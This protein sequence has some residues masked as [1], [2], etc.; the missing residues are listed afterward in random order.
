[1]SAVR[2]LVTLVL[3][4]LVLVA[5]GLALL[6]TPAGSAWLVGAVADLAGERLVLTGVRGT[7]LE[8]LAVDRLQL[9]AGRT[10]LVIAP[11]ELGMSWPD[12][13]RRRLRLTTARA[14]TVR[15]DI[16]PRPPGEPDSV[17]AP[18]LLPVVI[19][20]DSLEVHRL[21]IR[22][23]VGADGGTTAEIEPVEF[24]PLVLRGELADGDLRFESL[25]AELYGV[26]VD[27]SG[28]FGTGEPF[29]LSARLDW[30]APAAGVA[31]TGRVSGDLAALRFEQ[32]LR[33]PSLVSVGGFAHLLADQPEVIAEARWQGLE[34]PLGADPGLLLRSEEGRLRVRGWTDGYAGDADA[35]FLLGELPQ[36]RLRAKA[37]GDTSRVSLPEV[38]LDGF[39]G[40][41]AGSGDIDFREALAGSFRLQARRID[42]GTLDPRFAGQVDFSA[43]VS[44]DGVGNF[45]VNLPDAG[46]T[47]F[48]LPLRAS[49]TVS[50][51]GELLAFDGVRIDA[52]PNRAELGGTWGPKIAGQFRVD[53]PDLATLWPDYA[54]QLRGTGRF[55]GTT[56]R[57][58]LDVDLAGSNLATG[59]LRIRAL[60]ARG[61]LG[62]RQQLDVDAQADG[63]VYAGR[64]V[65]DLDARVSGPLESH[66]V[67]LNLTGGDV[68]ADLRSTGSYRN[69]V[70][71]QT[72]ERGV[73]TA[74]GD[75]EWS[76]R[77]PATIR[78]AG[79]DLSVTAHCWTSAGAELCLA[80]GSYGPAQFSGGVDLLQFPLAVLNRWLPSDIGLAGTATGSL[81]VAGDPRQP[82]LALRGRLQASLADTVITWRVPDD[83]D[84]QTA[85]TE[86]RATAAV[87]DDV[88]EFDVALAE[89]FGL[90]V[91]ADGTVTDPLGD[92][93]AI[94]AKV[95]GGVPDLAALGPLLERFADVGDLQGRIVLDATLTGNARQPDIAGGLELEDGALT[96]PAAGIRVDRIGLAV[97]GRADGQLVL[98]GNARSGKGYVAIDGA[99][100]WRNRLLPAAEATVKGR[101]F[102][103]INLP[104][105]LVQVSPD[106]RVVLADGQFR[107]GGE[108]LVPRAEIRLKKLA[109]SAVKPSPDTIVHGR[110]TV[111]VQQAPPLFVLDGLNVRLGERVSF[112]GFGLKT[113]LTGGLRLDQSLAADPR[114]VTADGVVSLRDGQFSAFGQNLAI[115]RGSLIFSGLVTDPGLDV[116]ASRDVDYEGREV[117]VGVLLSG[118]LSRIQTRIFS[119]PAMGELDALSYLTTGKPLSAAGAGDRSMVAS[120]A[121]TLGLS[122][123]LP[124]VQQLGTALSVD[125]V[126]FDSADASGTS[127]VV[128]EQ[129]GKNLYIRY[130]YAIFNKLG[131][132]QATYKLGRR[133]SI[134]GSS[135]EEQALDLIYSI[136]W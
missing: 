27:G 28:V 60:T 18:L 108:V 33:L 43:E 122:Q 127:V 25:R 113:G 97:Q 112:E 34:R 57:P 66:A 46:G 81:A 123:A 61:G 117:T 99:L 69:G 125:E 24:G 10:R 119:E 19:A 30:E 110:D 52:G 39:G 104:Q 72:I 79:A 35:T 78:R 111:V 106:V 1:V 68:G 67:E 71:T 126:G 90:R 6:G 129:L 38:L 54:G 102:D 74:P 22:N 9:A 45:R 65:G 48:G 116:K 87:A 62:P 13:L 109:D 77:E 51:Q 94:R 40:Q 136:N 59:E 118:N 16:A 36:A 100:D 17:V 124:V 70:I 14:D 53:A 95:A 3:T 98:K 115:E 50:R 132:V 103:I 88:L 58:T 82:D 64:V 21:V 26:R 20:V 107:V 23:G 120:S 114:L 80:D 15:I 37:T 91:T 133:V 47:L 134:E 75:Q 2:G 130:R 49:G 32:V 63:I 121:L 42:P 7:L 96:V 8:G 89:G 56:A 12:L 86:F 93:P 92:A 128:G 44:F 73:L 31:G 84:L 83:E 11:A 105:G 29:A 76:L 55:G 5:L 131:T 4:L 41:V 135:G 101:V 85:L